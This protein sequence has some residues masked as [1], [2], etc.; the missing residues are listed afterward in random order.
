MKR[1]QD[2]YDQYV[3]ESFKRG[4]LRQLTEQERAA[5]LD[6]LK[7]NWEDIQDQ[8]QGL[9]VVTDTIPKKC[10]KERLEAQMKQLEKDIELFEKH[11]IIYIGN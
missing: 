11:K 6:G 9:S 2:E 3:T 5:I 10:K 7:A 4:A 1:A 8:Y